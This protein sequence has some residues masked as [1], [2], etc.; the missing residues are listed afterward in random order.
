MEQ[1]KDK[2]TIPAESAKGIKAH[3]EKV[4]EHAKRVGGVMAEFKD[5]LKEYKIL[6]IAAGLV[7]GSAVTTLTT[8]IVSGLIMPALQLLIPSEAIKS[9]V[10]YVGSVTFKVGDV[11]SS[12]INFIIIALLFF[13]FVK[14]FMKK[15][16]VTKDALS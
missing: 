13:L 9:L 1:H 8:S 14:V 6:G 4:K 11:I 7:I 3:A 2:K 15:P 12:L 5:F 16:K 10:F